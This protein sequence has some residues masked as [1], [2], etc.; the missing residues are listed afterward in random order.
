[1]DRCLL[2]PFLP[3][4]PPS[5]CPSFAVTFVGNNTG[6]AATTIAWNFGGAP[7]DVIGPTNIMNP[8]VIFNT[9]GTYNVSLT[10]TNASGSQYFQHYFSYRKSC[11][12]V[13]F[14]AAMRPLD[15]FPFLFTFNNL[16]T[17]SCLEALLAGILEMGP[18]Q[19]APSPNQYLQIGWQLCSNA[20][21]NEQPGLFRH[22]KRIQTTFM[23]LPE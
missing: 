22:R 20:Y 4:T 1:M 6:G 2:R 10:L 21:C 9:P 3:L 7:P 12:V 15:V 23:F 18:Y 8:T 16:S 13:D 14:N 19:P 5:A 11:P 17:S